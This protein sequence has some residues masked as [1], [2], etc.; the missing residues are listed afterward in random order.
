[1][2]TNESVTTVE[3]IPDAEL[4]ARTLAGDRDAFNRIVSRYQIL[5]C[6]LAYSRIGHLGHSED[7]AQE[8]FITAWKRL[9][10]LRQPEK[11]RAWLCG[12]VHNRA[13]QC[14]RNEGRLP[15]RDAEP[16][17]TAADL[18][19]REAL[20]SEVTIS[21][22]EQAILWRSLEKIPDLYREPLIL[23]YREHRSI[24]HV[25]A[26]LELSEDAVKQR[27]SRGRKLL[28][29]GIEEFVEKTLR[30]T[31][32]TPA[33]S[34]TV[35]AALP[36]TGG[37]AT[38]AGVGAAGKGTL[39]AKTALGAFLLPFVGVFTGFAAQWLMF[40]GPGSP[41]TKLR[42]VL[43]WLSV[44]TFAIGGNYAVNFAGHHYNWS[45]PVFFSAES[46]FW[47]F[48]SMCLATWIIPMYRHAQKGLL[49]REAARVPAAP[50]PA[51]RYA[52]IVAGTHIMMFWGLVQAA[53]GNRD[54]L[55]LAIVA[56]MA[57]A[58]GI[59]NFFRYHRQN[60]A[61]LG[62]AYMEQLASC[63][64]VMLVII[65]LRSDVWV[66]TRYGISVVELH[67][68]MPIWIIPALSL[69]LVLWSVFLLIWTKPGATGVA[70]GR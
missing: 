53:W 4:V 36:L 26:E 38:A 32:P 67:S 13:K 29:E 19:T 37:S 27:L 6:S 8:T 52:T 10:L 60:G 43:T 50:I 9:R 22:E 7:V 44:L 41:V 35:L 66:A 23:F 62:L 39:A 2:I 59:I 3:Y 12:I 69:A 42:L 65:N 56:G 14:L 47:W 31:A 18:P 61:G 30:R 20:P 15:L 70:S 21:H 16:L 25:A 48:Y 33:F 17:E 11:L 24:E 49:A 55:G 63:T 28:Q 46:G 68:R 64:V 58:L 34:N 45:D 54:Y 40:R 57:T 5:I 51:L 1:M